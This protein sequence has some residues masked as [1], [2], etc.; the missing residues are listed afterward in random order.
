MRPPSIR[1]SLAICLLIPL[2]ALAQTGSSVVQTL[3]IEVKPITKIAVS[4]NPGALYITDASAGSDVLS[5]SDNNSNYSMM[6]NLDNMKIV[7]SINN[8]MPEGT[9]LMMKLESSKGSSNGFVDVS[10]A[11]SPVEVVTALGKG[12][13]LN[14]SITYTFAANASIGQINVDSRVVTLTLTN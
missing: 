3:N 2:V 10:S 11:M 13:D 14:Q 6:T 8:P 5:V 7:A 12:S 9:R 1:L 4:G